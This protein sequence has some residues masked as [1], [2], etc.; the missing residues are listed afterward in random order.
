M[1]RYRKKPVEIDAIQYKGYYSDEIKE[2]FGGDAHEFD[3]AEGIRIATLE[4]V[5]LATPFDWIV[6]G[7]KGELYPV[8]PDIFEATYEAVES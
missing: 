7:V 8:K 2:F 5:M 1:S 6:R 3:N 4:G